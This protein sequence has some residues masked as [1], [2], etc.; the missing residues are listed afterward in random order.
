M[1]AKGPSTLLLGPR[2]IPVERPDP[3]KRVMAPM[4]LSHLQSLTTECHRVSARATRFL[5]GLEVPPAPWTWGSH[6]SYTGL[7]SPGYGPPAGFLTLLTACSS[8]SFSGLF[9]PVTLMGFYPPEP[10]SSQAAATSSD[11]RCRLGVRHSES[12]SSARNVGAAR[13]SREH[14]IVRST[15]ASVHRS[16]PSSRPCS[17]SESA[18]LP[19][20]G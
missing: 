9:H 1:P 7:A 2:G 19:P 3:P 11:V 10:C 17:T 5:P 20:E 14:T 6:V 15:F 12:R 8:P 16:G 18:T 4:G 13:A